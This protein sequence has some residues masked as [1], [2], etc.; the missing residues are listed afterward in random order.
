MLPKM[1]YRVTLSRELLLFPMMTLM[2]SDSCLIPLLMISRSGI[3][4]SKDPGVPH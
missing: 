2:A 4:F 3:R 1:R